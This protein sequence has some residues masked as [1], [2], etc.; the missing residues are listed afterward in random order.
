LNIKLSF[1]RT[2]ESVYP[3]VTPILFLF[4]TQLS[5]AQIGQPHLVERGTLIIKITGFEND[6][7]DCWFGLDN[8]EEVF[9]S[10]DTVFIGKI[11]P[12]VNGEVNFTIDSLPYGNYAIRVFHDENGNSELDTDILGIPSEDYGYSNDA[13]GW[14]GPP[15]WEKA[16]FLFNEKEMIVLIVV[17]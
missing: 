8:S 11:L 2:R 12:I 6:K 15:S 17:D 9:E 14:F 3:V 16:E 4:F 1:P 7:G 13:S 5:I 10:E